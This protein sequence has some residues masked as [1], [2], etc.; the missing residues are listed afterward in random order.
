MKGEIKCPPI[1]LAHASTRS[2]EWIGLNRAY[3]DGEK[4][5]SER[6]VKVEVIAAWKRRVEL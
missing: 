4:L 1:I 3:P 6:T 2:I 5:M